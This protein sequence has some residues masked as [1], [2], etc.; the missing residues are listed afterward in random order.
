MCNPPFYQSHEELQEA[1]DGKELEP[2]AVTVLYISF[3]PSNI[4]FKKKRLAQVQKTS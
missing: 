4:F 1:L 3:A 2:A